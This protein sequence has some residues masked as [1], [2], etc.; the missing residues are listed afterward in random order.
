M[1]TDFYTKFILTVIA[2]GLFAN[3]GS[4]FIGEARAEG[5]ATSRYHAQGVMRI[6]GKAKGNRNSNGDMAYD[7]DCVEVKNGALLVRVVK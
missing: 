1:K 2:I 7:R 6:C 5:L 3:A 4:D